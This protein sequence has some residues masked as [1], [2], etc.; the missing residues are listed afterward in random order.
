MTH[1]DL[2]TTVDVVALSGLTYGRVNYWVKRGWITPAVDSQGSGTVRL[3]HPSAV[4]KVKELAAAMDACPY[5]HD[6]D[7]SSGAS[8]AAKVRL[9]EAR[10]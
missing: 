4:D 3:F 10:Q 7:R 6:H 8:L 2:I 1:S 9:A 5:P